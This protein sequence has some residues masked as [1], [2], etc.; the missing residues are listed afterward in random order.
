MIRIEDNFEDVLGKAMSGLGLN[1]DTLAAASGLEAA[2]I[3]SLLSGSINDE[4]LR[5]LAPVL[6]LSPTKLVDMAHQR[7]QPSVQLPDGV[8]LFNTPFPVPGYEEMTVNSFLIW[9]GQEAAAFDTGANA[10]A[11]LAEVEKQNLRLNA[12]YITHTHRDHIAA[13]GAIRKTCPET[14]VYRPESEPLPG[15]VALS[16]GARHACGAFEIETRL[17]SGHS[18]GA[19]SYIV[20]GGEVPLAFVGDTLFCLSMGKAPREA[21]AVALEN[22]RRELLSMPNNTILCPGHG[23]VTTVRD[24]KARS[25][26]F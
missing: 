12:L 10:N 20:T 11:L 7:W 25:P 1:V 15:A 19:L 17:T 5:T 22:N 4:A 8:A 14:T 3:R 26:F 21:Y 13:L 18:P 2:H 9:S 16:A 24:E 6:K 23:P